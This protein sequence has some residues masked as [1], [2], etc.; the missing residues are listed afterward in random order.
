MA[1]IMSKPAKL[2]FRNGKRQLVS[3]ESQSRKDYDKQYNRRRATNNRDYT[4]FYKTSQWLHTRKTVLLR[5]YGICVRC[6]L[7]G[8]I[9]D[10]II[11]SEDDW[12]NRLDINNLETLCQRCHQLKTKREWIKRHKGVKR[13]M[14]IHIL[15][16]YP[17][18]GKSTYVANHITDND[19]VYDY[20]LLSSSL[21][22]S[23][24]NL[25][26]GNQSQTDSLKT[27][28]DHNLDISDY[29]ALIY[30]LILRKIKAEQTFDNVWIIQTYPD[31]RLVTLLAAYDVEWLRLDTSRHDCIERLMKQN[32]DISEATKVMNKLDQE[33]NEEKFSM[34]KTIK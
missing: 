19:L 12:N 7:E 31:E 32:R 15:V 29:V 25:I 23:M 1:G 10:H 33:Y 3:Y 2:V 21:D 28:H 8:K 14:K 22:G 26:N 30:E 20:D 34:I 6:G 18:S 4:D 9:V 5:D 27:I 17:G 24:L 16:G 11:P 13:A